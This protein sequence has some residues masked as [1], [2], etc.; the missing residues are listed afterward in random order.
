M[1]PPHRDVRGRFI[2]DEKGKVVRDGGGLALPEGVITP[3][4][5]AVDPGPIMGPTRVGEWLMV[6]VRVAKSVPKGT[7]L[8]KV[9]QELSER[10]HCG[11]IGP[12][13]TIVI[14]LLEA[15]REDRHFLLDRTNWPTPE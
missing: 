2:V 8:F 15:H 13:A 5:L 14:D 1:M 6:D 9:C 3:P 7:R 4:E 10:G 12:T 11:I